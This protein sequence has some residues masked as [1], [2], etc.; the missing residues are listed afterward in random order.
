M[1]WKRVIQLNKWDRTLRNAT[2]MQFLC[3]LKIAF[4]LIKASLMHPQNMSAN[5]SELPGCQCIIEK[6]I[7]EHASKW[8]AGRQRASDRTTRSLNSDVGEGFLHLSYIYETNRHI[9]D[10]QTA[11]NSQTC[12][13]DK[14]PKWF[15]SLTASQD[16]KCFQTKMSRQAARWPRNGTQFVCI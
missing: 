10:L 7:H 8:A 3:V 9:Q 12:L 16:F 5:C 6:H 15:I 11:T 1:V 14:T 2:Q 4:V 13:F